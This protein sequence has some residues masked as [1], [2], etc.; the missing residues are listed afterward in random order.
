M[1]KAKLKAADRSKLLFESGGLCSLCCSN[2]YYDCFSRTQIQ[3]GEY[4]HMIADSPEGPRGN[5]RS[6][7]LA[8]DIDNIILLC[9]SCHSKVDKKP[10]LYP[11]EYLY[12][13]RDSHLKLVREMLGSLC[14]PKALAIIYTAPIGGHNP[15]IDEVKMNAAIRSSGFLAP[16]FPED[17]NPNNLSWEDTNAEYWVYHWKQLQENFKEKI[18][19]RQERGE[20]KP[21]LLF[22]IAPQPLLIRLGMLINDLCDVRVFQK[23]REPDTWKWLAEEVETRYEITSPK[24]R[25][26]NVA[27]NLS[28]SADIENERIYS[29]LGEDTSIWKIT[30]DNV[31]NDYLR[32][33]TQLEALRKLYRDFFLEVKKFHGHNTIL[34]VFP[35]C[36][37]SAV[38]EFGRVYMPKADL[39]LV[40][41][42]QNRKRNAFEKAYDLSSGD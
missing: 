23:K 37:P 5:E 40:L 32:T 7:E 17:L 8:S 30:H 16:R 11:I 31:H 27:L 20:C 25:R 36:P 34:H 24:E 29:V 13:L 21:Y 38:I 10:L 33:P 14:N 9:P 6:E 28:L 15:K 42:D 1:S 3:F 4:A 18:A 35:A 39:P 19:I 22:A 12:K 41:Y 2:I 26:K